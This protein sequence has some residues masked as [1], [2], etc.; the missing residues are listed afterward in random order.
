VISARWSIVLEE[1]ERFTIHMPLWIHG[2]AFDREPSTPL[3]AHSIS[4]APRR[5]NTSK[6]ACTNGGI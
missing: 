4:V 1:R 5:R 3:P 6:Y 2:G